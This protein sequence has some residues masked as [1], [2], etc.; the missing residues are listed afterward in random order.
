M[1]GEVAIAPSTLAG[2]QA[3]RMGV[4]V[5]DKNRVLK[6]SHSWE[7]KLAENQLILLSIQ[8]KSRQESRRGGVGGE[9][10]G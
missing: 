8:Y 4:C 9:R 2:R 10:N 1:V 5:S 6:H 7:E 3:G